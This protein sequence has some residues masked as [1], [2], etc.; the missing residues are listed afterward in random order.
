MHWW[1]ETERKSLWPFPETPRLR[2]FIEGL[3]PV[4][5]VLTG[6]GADRSNTESKSELSQDGSQSLPNG[7]DPNTA[8]LTLS[9]QV[10]V[11]LHGNLIVVL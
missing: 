11:A 2:V 6:T 8:G 5:H 4:A 3:N 10:H 7:A 9:A 1:F